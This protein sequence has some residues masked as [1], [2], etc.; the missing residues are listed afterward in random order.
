[1]T[2]LL[3]AQYPMRVTPALEADPPPNSALEADPLPNSPWFLVEVVYEG[4]FEKC[5][6][7]QAMGATP[8]Y[9]TGL[10]NPIPQVHMGIT[11]VRYVPEL[12]NSSCAKCHGPVGNAAAAGV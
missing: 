5:A 6:P 10:L 2:M 4:A 1:M 9:Q 12:H 7:Q 8:T 3:C 11:S